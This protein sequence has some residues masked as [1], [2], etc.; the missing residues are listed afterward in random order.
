MQLARGEQHRPAVQRRR[1]SRQL[2]QGHEALFDEQRQEVVTGAE[3]TGPRDRRGRLD[4]ERR[5]Q[6]VGDQ[7]QSAGHPEHGL[8]RGDLRGLRLGGAA[9]GPHGTLELLLGDLHDLRGQTG[10]VGEGEHGGLVP[11]EQNGAGALLLRVARGAAGGAVV[12][13]RGGLSGEQAGCFFVADLGAYLVADV[14]HARHGWLPRDAVRGETGWLPARGPG[15]SP[16]HEEDNGR[17]V[18]GV[19]PQGERNRT[20]RRTGS[21]PVRNPALIVNCVWTQGR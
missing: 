3:R 15:G 1:H 20:I 21:R 7:D 17:S 12:T 16:A 10:G 6:L 9:D 8:L 2:G 13:A 11:D 14:E 4:D 18:A 5:V 19:T